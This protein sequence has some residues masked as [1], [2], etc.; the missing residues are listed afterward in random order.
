MKKKKQILEVPPALIQQTRQVL[1]EMSSQ[2][3]QLVNIAL[4]LVSSVLQD[5]KKIQLVGSHDTDMSN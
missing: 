1:K 3:G 5:I 2:F 4:S